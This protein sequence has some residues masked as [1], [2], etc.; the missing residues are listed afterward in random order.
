M[1][2]ADFSKLWWSVPFL[3]AALAG[4]GAATADERPAGPAA[5]AA[6]EPAPVAG[7]A[8]ARL[9]VGPLEEPPAP[10]PPPPEPEPLRLVL[11]QAEDFL[12]APFPPADPSRYR[13]WKE[14]GRIQVGQSHLQHAELVDGEQTVLV[15]SGM[16]NAVRVY[17]RRTRA[18][19][20]TIPVDPVDD[21]GRSGLA[22]WPDGGVEPG[23]LV[24][25]KDGLWLFATTSGDALRRFD[26]AFLWG[27][28]WSPDRR[29][30]VG[31]ASDTGTQTSVLHFYHRTGPN[32]LEKLAA[33]PLAERVDGFDLSRDNRYLAVLYYPSDTLELIDLHTGR[34]LWRVPTP[35]YCAD[36]SLSPDGRAVAAGGAGLLLVD[37]AHP[38][39]RTVYTRFQNNAGEVRFSPSGDAVVTSSYDGKVRVFG[40]SLDPVSLNLLKTLSHGGTANVYALRF[41]GGGRGLMSSSGDRTVRFWGGPARRSAAA[42]KVWKPF[43]YPRPS[44]QEADATAPLDWNALLPEARREL[45]AEL[46][47]TPRHRP[48]R[49]DGP[50]SPSKI[51]PGRY[52][53]RV[54]TGYKL[55]DCVVETDPN[56]HVML[57]VKEGNLIPMRGVLYDDGNVVR[58]EGA[59]TTTQP[60]SCFGCQDRCYLEP[61]TCGCQPDPPYRIR[62]CLS[63]PLHA[64]LRKAGAKWRGVV[65]YAGYADERIPLRPPPADAPFEDGIAQYTIELVPR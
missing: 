24:G 29:I 14:Q 5:L 2:T 25:R 23:F 33:I 61:G 17:D 28:R 41:L 7:T 12:S 56:G 30:L 48:A 37:A 34:A 3:C 18:L 64:V 58:F 38:E 60:F 21:C 32:T 42:G 26:D 35:D 16:E 57:E 45:L 11:P 52:A 27:L 46:R 20:S 8:P 49:L 36:V 65:A 55:R 51:R 13:G 22:P 50:P 15:M 19:K 47:A 9:A 63:Q 44:G 6:G 4:C 54:G 43:V 10:G 40:W 59:S 1:M 62:A 53:C 39:R 31:V